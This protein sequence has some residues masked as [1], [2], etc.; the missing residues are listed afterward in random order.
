M[1]GGLLQL[2]GTVERLRMPAFFNG[3]SEKRQG[4]CLVRYKG[5]WDPSGQPQ[6]IA[7]QIQVITSKQI[8]LP[9]YS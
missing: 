7:T 4:I 5:K 1:K 8:N 9:C 6:K 2:G 3:A